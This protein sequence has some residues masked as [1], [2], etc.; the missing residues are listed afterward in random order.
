MK[1]KVFRDPVHNYIPVEDEL[2]YDLINSKEFQRLRRI[3]QLGSSSFTFHGA[4]HSRFSHCLGV[5]YLAR[6]VT[7]IFDKKYSDIWN[8]NESLLT[9]TAALLHDIGHGAYSHTFER[10]FDTNHET[11]TQQIILSPETEINTILRRVSPDF[12]DKVASV[13]NHTYS[14]KQV[15]QLISSQIDVDRMD[16][17]LRDSYFTG[18]SYGEFDLTRVL[19][20]IRPIENGIAFSRDGMHA[21]EDYIISRYQMYMQVYFHPASRAMEV[22]LQNLLK[23]AKYLYPKEKEFFTVTSPHLI[24]FFENRV[25]LEDYL[26]LDDGV[27]NTYFQTWMQSADKILS[28]LASRF[29]NRKVFK[30]IT[31]DEKDLSNLEKLREIVKDLGFDPTYYTALHLNFDLPYDVYKPDVQNPRTQIEMLQEDGSIA[32]LSTLSPLVHTLS[33]TT[34]GNRRFYF[35]KEMLIKD[36]LFVE[37]KEKFSHYIKNKHF[38]NLRE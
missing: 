28:D 34:H 20:V 27:M 14:N 11:I 23:R 5:Y 6:R 32:E 18:A 8:S 17:L 4:E 9:M 31:F 7:N 3:K 35:P 36:D 25:T 38:Y 21:V 33:G 24:P 30:S 29:I 15:E 19:R 1:E 22:L 10:L 13:I 2:I 12:P 37:A 26:S 16:Y